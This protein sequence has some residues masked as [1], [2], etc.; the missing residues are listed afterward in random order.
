M[1][2][3][4]Q[5]QA[6]AEA[7]NIDVAVESLQDVRPDVTDTHIGEAKTGAFNGSTMIVAA[8]PVD[9]MVTDALRKGLAAVG[10]N[11]VD[12]ADAD[13]R[14]TGQITEFWVTEH[15]TG[16][17]LEYAKAYVKYDLLLKDTQG[18][19]LW[20]STVDKYLVSDDCWDATE[21]NTPT[22]TKAL[23]NS[24]EALLSDQTFWE[25]IID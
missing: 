13:Y 24:V 6:R 12:G 14:V 19:I 7:E 5:L 23:Q 20:G 17:S 9:V 10:F 15:A 4:L 2:P 3:V 16:F 25:A 22:L 8:E 21:F 1:R 11:V 18:K